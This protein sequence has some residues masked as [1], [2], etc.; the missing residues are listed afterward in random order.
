M[1]TIS[2]S[3]QID[4]KN[5][6]KKKMK[7]LKYKKIEK[8][9]E[10]L[11]CTE[12]ILNQLN[13]QKSQ[14][15]Q[16]YLKTSLSKVFEGVKLPTK[17]DLDLLAIHIKMTNILI[18]NCIQH[19]NNT[20]YLSDMI[21]TLSIIE[22]EFR[23]SEAHYRDWQTYLYEKFCALDQDIGFTYLR[24][25]NYQTELGIQPFSTALQFLSKKPIPPNSFKPAKPQSIEANNQSILKKY[26]GSSVFEAQSV[27]LTGTA[28][29]G[30]SAK[31][32]TFQDAKI[33]K[34]GTVIGHGHCQTGNF[35][36]NG[37]FNKSHIKLTKQYE[38]KHSVIYDG[39]FKKQGYIE[40]EWELSEDK[41]GTFKI[42]F[43]NFENWTGHYVNSGHK[44]VMNIKMGICDGVISG[45]GTESN[46]L[47][48]YIIKGNLDPQTNSCSFIMHCIE[49]SERYFYGKF[50]CQNKTIEGI[51]LENDQFC[52]EF[53]LKKS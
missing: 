45:I 10:K 32:M 26:N 44:S 14:E 8:L 21:K 25:E 31:K 22:S 17:V 2:K 39:S 27:N 46:R 3:L 9:T 29:W 48:V 7:K 51:W 43:L 35:Y 36:I 4:T 49:I 1:Q 13:I 28:F 34:D 30:D 23:H 19:K 12:N 11:N 6:Q 52:G 18:D 50:D 37:K 47:L 41:T 42:E 53:L 15:M 5:V 24:Y 20:E 33:Y 16:E 40:G 38:Y